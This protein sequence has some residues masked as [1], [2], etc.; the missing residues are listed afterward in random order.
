MLRGRSTRPD[1]S[2]KPSQLDSKKPD[3]ALDVYAL[4]A[5][6]GNR[7]LNSTWLVSGV[8]CYGETAEELFSFTDQDRPIPGN[9]LLRITSGIQQTMQGDFTGFD[10]GSS[11][12]WILIRAWE[13]NGFY[14]E[15]ND[16]KDKERLS[17]HFPSMQE[18]EGAYPPSV[19]LFI[20]SKPD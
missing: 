15:I 4:I 8:D 16:P 2:Q 6:L 7:A 20:P 9:D 13:G 19:G 10:P 17:T 14:I 5:A 12:H 11:S 18:V 3:Q 1:D